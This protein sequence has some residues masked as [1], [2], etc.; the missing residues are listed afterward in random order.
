MFADL[1]AVIVDADQA[2]RHVVAV[3]S[4]CWHELRD[5]LGPHYFEPDGRLKRREIRECIVRDADCRTKVNA[6]L[7]PA[8]IRAME[9][10]WEE[11]QNAAPP[12]TVIFDIPLLFE[13][14][15]SDRFDTIIL[16]YVPAHVQAARLMDRDGLTASEAERTLT[17][18]MDIEVKRGL[19]HVVLDNGGSLEMTRR[20]VEAVWASIRT[21]GPRQ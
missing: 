13:S 1:G 16:V 7:H 5:L 6:I 3:G 19:A 21:I 8:I 15:L 12:K 14:G 9:S 20:Q 4:S 11:N 17:M 2:A 18:Q 10:R